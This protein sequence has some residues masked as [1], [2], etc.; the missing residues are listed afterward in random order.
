[1]SKFN[2]KK[3][4]FQ[5]MGGVIPAII[6]DAKT[7]DVLMLGFMNEEALRITL[8]NKRVTFWSRDKKRLW[9]KGEVSGNKL[10]VVSISPDCDKDTLLIFVKPRGPVC[11][12]GKETCF[13]IERAISLEFLRELYDL[14]VV[15]KKG[16]PKNSYTA[17]LFK[18]GLAKI[19]E[20]VEEESGEVVFAAKKE[21]RKRLIEESADL[22]YHL[23][24][25]LVEK[26]ISLE[27]IIKEL[28]QRRK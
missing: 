21:S 13:G 8:K 1:M 23:F 14:L 20:K 28:K 27:D 24:V 19:L 5:K 7:K 16:L 22:L 12:T 15:R 18:K 4:N 17:F 6:Q 9:E 11:H 2:V 25:L 10:D 26:N 3:L